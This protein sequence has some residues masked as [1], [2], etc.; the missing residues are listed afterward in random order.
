[1]NN[2]QARIDEAIDNFDIVNVI[3]KVYALFR[4]NVMQDFVLV[5]V[6]VYPFPKNLNKNLLRSR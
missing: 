3:N 2:K 1:M 6:N 5:F 4:I